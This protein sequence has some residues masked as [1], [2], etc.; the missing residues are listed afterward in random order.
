MNLQIM[1][2]DQLFLKLLI[3]FICYIFDPSDQYAKGFEKRCLK[4]AQ[5]YSHESL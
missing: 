1:L 2:I 3:L 4:K 5:I